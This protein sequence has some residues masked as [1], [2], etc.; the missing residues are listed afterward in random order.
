MSE[1]SGP[2]LWPGA[3][4]HRRITSPLRRYL[5]TAFIAVSFTSCAAPD[6]AKP[7]AKAVEMPDALRTLLV[8]RYFIGLDPHDPAIDA[9]VEPMRMPQAMLDH[10]AALPWEAGQLEKFGDSKRFYALV[11]TP[12]E[13]PYAI[14]FRGEVPR[15]VRE[16]DEAR[17]R[18][19]KRLYS[20]KGFLAEP[21]KELEAWLAKDAKPEEALA[22]ATRLATPALDAETLTRA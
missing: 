14:H 3:T 21:A 12:G 18:I 22:R 10:V 8:E 11:R 17:V 13:K 1:V 19:L 7:A 9:A 16:L 15:S 6:A 20:G 5:A 4:T 2:T